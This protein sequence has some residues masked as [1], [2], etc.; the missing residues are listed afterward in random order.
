M[1]RLPS[2]GMIGEP[3]RSGTSHRTTPREDRL[4]ARYARINRFATSTRILDEVYFG[5]HVS[6]RSVDIRINEQRLRARIPIQW[7]QL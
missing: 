1:E 3:L 7:L 2:T 5:G 4:I 6:V